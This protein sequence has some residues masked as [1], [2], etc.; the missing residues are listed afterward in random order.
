MDAAL[1]VILVLCFTGWHISHEIFLGRVCALF[2][3]LEGSQTVRE[4]EPSWRSEK[5]PV[6]SANVWDTVPGAETSG[7]IYFV[8]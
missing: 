4:V 5:D 3:S 8:L 1:E 6:G 7:H 2:L